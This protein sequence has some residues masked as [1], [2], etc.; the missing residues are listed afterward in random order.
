[1]Y[2]R[3]FAFGCSFTNFSWP[4]WA[5][6]IGYDL[7]LPFENWGIAGTGNVA[8]A[9]RM[10]ECDLK[11]TFTDRDL[12]LVNWSSWHREDRI[13]THGHWAS[14]GN[15]FNNNLFD[16]RFIKRHWTA[17]ND[18][19]KNSSSIISSNKLFNI[20]YQSHMVDYESSV[21]YDYN[22]EYNFKEFQY[23]LDNLPEKN[24]FDNRNNSRF[25][26]RVNDSH[27]DILTHLN[28]AA[29]I[30][31]NLNLTLQDGTINKYTELQRIVINDIK[32]VLQW[33]DD[34]LIN[35]FKGNKYA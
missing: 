9:F 14:G 26:L 20:A 22:P 8:I 24:V 10:L 16:K 2:N 31:K 6:I 11:N 13:N 30:Y 35:F 29:T 33:H 15:I 17:Q 18:I 34:S 12:I 5:D 23:L 28:H 32:S 7:G 1:M 19:V 25:N 3:I 4:T 27:P 21:E